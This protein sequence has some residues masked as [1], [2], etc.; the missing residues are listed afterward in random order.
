M[1]TE[2]KDYGEGGDGVWVPG[3]GERG[4]VGRWFESGISIRAAVLK[5]RRKIEKKVRRKCAWG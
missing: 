5:R 2:T 3:G 1:V 4:Q